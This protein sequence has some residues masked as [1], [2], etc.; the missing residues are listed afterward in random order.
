ML[1]SYI[2]FSSYFHFSIYN[3]LLLLLRIC[4]KIILIAGLSCSSANG[5]SHHEQQSFLCTPQ[6]WS[7]VSFGC[8]SS[9]QISQMVS[10]PIRTWTKLVHVSNSIT[11]DSLLGG[12]DR[13]SAQENHWPIR[14]KDVIPMLS[15][16]WKNGIHCILCGYQY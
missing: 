6:G 10:G 1:T 16:Q 9:H 7:C 11:N 13:V 2:Y 14:R 4:L 3:R 15:S 12:R 5:S 8:E